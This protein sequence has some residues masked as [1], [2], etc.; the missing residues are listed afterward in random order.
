MTDKLTGVD[1]GST[2]AQAGIRRPSKQLGDRKLGDRKP[3]SDRRNKKRHRIWYR[4][5]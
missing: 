1:K 4:L 2:F 3:N 5:S